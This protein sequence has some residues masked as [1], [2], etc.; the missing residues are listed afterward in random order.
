LSFRFA[1]AIVPLGEPGGCG[2]PTFEHL[3]ISLTRP[4]LPPILER[5]DHR[6]HVVPRREYLERAFGQRREFLHMGRRC[7]YVPL[8]AVGEI[9]AGFFAREVPIRT[10]DAELHPISYEGWERAFFAIDLDAHKQTF[11]MQHN[12]KVGSP[13]AVLEAFFDTLQNDQEFTDY[14]VHIEYLIND[15]TYWRI[16]DQYVGQIT[17]IAFTFLPPNAYKATEKVTQL[18]QALTPETGTDKTKHVYESKAGHLNPRSDLLAASAEVAIEGAGDLTI[19]V[20]GRTVFSSER[21]RMVTTV[22]NDAIPTP[23]DP[24]PLTGLLRRLFG[25]L[26]RD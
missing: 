20:G 15:E 18:L 19:K 16:A 13:R 10:A 25:G 9:Y 5:I 24:G 21:G 17:Q 3:R 6:E 14:Q 7:A 26:V 23:E 11:A 2:V 1:R 12:L 4:E 22:A 8:K